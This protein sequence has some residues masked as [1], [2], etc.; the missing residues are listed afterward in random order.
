MKQ[1]LYF[2]NQYWEI[3]PYTI[4]KKDI[5]EIDHE[6]NRKSIDFEPELINNAITLSDSNSIVIDERLDSS[7]IFRFLKATSGGSDGDNLTREDAQSLTKKLLALGYLFSKGT[8]EPKGIIISGADFEKKIFSGIVVPIMKIH[9]VD[10]SDSNI[11]KDTYLF[12][13]LAEDTDIITY[14]DCSDEIP[15]GWFFN[16]ISHGIRVEAKGEEMKILPPKKLQLITER[17]P[18]SKSETHRFF[19][20]KLSEI[21]DQ[22]GFD[23]LG[24]LLDSRWDKSQWNLYY[25]L[26][27]HAIQLYMK[28][29]FKIS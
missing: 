19:D 16:Q 27:A 6:Q 29:G 14:V 24:R 3:T 20:I 15:L 7:D 12:S 23:Y 13:D 25:N 8:N 17:E 1:H 2:T 11:E 4:I 21:L 9:W 18:Q 28:F 5:H 26:A 22:D 10:A